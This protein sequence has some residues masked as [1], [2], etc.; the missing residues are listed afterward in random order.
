MVVPYGLCLHDPGLRGFRLVCTIWGSL[1]PVERRVEGPP[2]GAPPACRSGGLEE[3][4]LASW[5][6]LGVYFWVLGLGC[7]EHPSCPVQDQPLGIRFEDVDGRKAG[8]V[9]RGCPMLRRLCP[10]G[11]GKGVGWPSGGGVD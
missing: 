4:L 11:T 3:S 2:R 9:R 8:G 7:H 5:G 1:G 6:A 10:F